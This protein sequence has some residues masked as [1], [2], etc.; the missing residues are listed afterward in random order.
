[1]NKI[2]SFCPNCGA[3]LPDLSKDFVEDRTLRCEYCSYSLVIPSE[4]KKLRTF[5]YLMNQDY[6][7]KEKKNKEN[8]QALIAGCFLVSFLIVV[9][10]GVFYGQIGGWISFIVCL[11]ASYYS[12]SKFI[13]YQK[14]EK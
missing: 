7:T 1:M 2:P 4:H 14:S 8:L 3:K 5:K 13:N 12:V 11:A 9:N 6:K 10:M